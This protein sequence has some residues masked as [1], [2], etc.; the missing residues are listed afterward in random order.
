MWEQ[1]STTNPPLVC[2][3]DIEIFVKYRDHRKFMYFMMDLHEDF[4]L[5]RA[6]LFSRSPTPSLDAVVKELISEENRRPTHHMSSSDHVLATPSPQSPITAFIA[7]P[8]INS[9]SPTSQS[10]KSTRCKFCRAK[11]HDISVCR[12]LHKF[13]QEQNIVSLPRVAAVCP[14]NPLV[15][16]S[17]SLVSSLTTAD[18]EAIVQQVLSHTSTAL[19]VTSGKQPWFFDTA[20]C[21]H[22]TPD[23]S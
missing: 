2:S 21:N 18:I 20:C 11:D 10:F 19:S 3:K 6:S 15:P 9:R 16:T 17:P 12:K 4:E 22:M 8:R 13:V 23:E 5:T 1:L 14:S 7:P